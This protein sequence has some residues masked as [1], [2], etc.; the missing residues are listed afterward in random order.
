LRAR[1]QGKPG[2]VAQI[3]GGAFGQLTELLQMAGDPS[4]DSARKKKILDL[5]AADSGRFATVLTV[6]QRQQVGALADQVAQAWPDGKAQAAAIKAGL[7]QAP[8]GKLCT[9]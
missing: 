9:A 7:T 4:L 2:A 5:V 1:L 6:A 8:C 3:R